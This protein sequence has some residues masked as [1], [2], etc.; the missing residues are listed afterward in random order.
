MFEL[1]VVFT[2]SF[3][4]F[5]ESGCFVLWPQN[6]LSGWHF[7]SKRASRIELFFRCDQTIRMVELNH[8]DDAGNH[9]L[10]RVQIDLKGLLL[11]LLNDAAEMFVIRI[12]LRFWRQPG[13]KVVGRNLPQIWL[14]MRSS[15]QWMRRINGLVMTSRQCWL[16]HQTI[17]FVC[18]RLS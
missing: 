12:L 8:V 15:V 18:I 9:L 3:S 2:S 6:Q 10:H 4:Q 11:I 14:T 1:L 5:L 13:D 7:Q 16:N 17:S